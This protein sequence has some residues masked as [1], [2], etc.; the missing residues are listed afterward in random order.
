MNRWGDP[1]EAATLDE[2][3][4]ALHLH[5]RQ[6]AQQIER[7]AIRKLWQ[8]QVQRDRAGHLPPAALRKGA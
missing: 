7:R 3:A 8:R 1:A 5:N 6:S 2:T 4:R